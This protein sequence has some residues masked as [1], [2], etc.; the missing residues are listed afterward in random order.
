MDD[1]HR[2]S[3][4]ALIDKARATG[5]I[6][7][8]KSFF[9]EP[10]FTATHVVHDPATRKAAI[11]DSV[12]D[13]DQPS[14]R[15]GHASAD[16]I[17]DYVRREG[18]TV[19]WQ[20]E[21]HAHADHLSAAPYL[22]EKLGGQIVIGRH[23]E[24]VQTVFGAI[25][26][27]DERFARDG[28]Q[29][30]RLMADGERFMLGEIEGMVLH[31]PGHTPACMVWIIGDA[32]FTGDTLFMPDYGTARADFPGGDARTL[33]RSIQR[34]LSLPGE[35]RL[36]L[37]HDY[38]APGRDSFAWETTIAAERTANVH[39]HEGVDEDQFVAMR[40]ARDK[41]LSMPRLILPSIQVNM[42]AGHFPEPE[43]NGTRYLKLPLDTL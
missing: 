1:L 19:E 39:V 15:T 5:R 37:C 42:R 31:T 29:F 16:A 6:P 35:T 7:V 28:S 3:A 17:V 33:Y 38:K 26:N 24:T 41:T 10:T 21:T 12:L 13:F 14:G 40:E 30:D 27:E 22:Q 8:V 4:A 23:I 18:L 43:A 2:D 20:I 11:I 34:L 36:F 25:F 9:D 32:L